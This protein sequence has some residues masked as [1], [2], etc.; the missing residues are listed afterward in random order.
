MPQEANANASPDSAP[1]TLGAVSPGSLDGLARDLAMPMPRGKALRTLAAGLVVASVPGMTA[2]RARA[3]DPPPPCSR[4]GTFCGNVNPLGQIGYNIGCCLGGPGETRTVCC[5]GIPG[6][7]GSLCCPTGY[8][9]GNK[10]KDSK[11]NCICR[12]KVVCGSTCCKP[13]EYC[14]FNLLGSNFCEKRCPNGDEKCIGN[15]CTRNEECGFFGCSCKSGFVSAGTGN[16]VPP[17]KDPGDPNPGYNPFRNMF[18]MMGQSSAASGGGRSRRAMF[19]RSDR[20]SSAAV[21]RALDA[22]AAVNGQGAAAMLAIRDGK[23][24]PAFRQKVKVARATPPKVS[25][26]AVLNAGS[27]AALNKLLVAEAE[28]YALIAAMTTAL[29]RFRAAQAKQKSAAGSQLRASATF[30]GQAVTALKKI[31]GLR[32]AAARALKGGKVPEAWAFDPAVNTFV[33]AVRSGG[34][35]ASLR[36]PMARLGVGS[37]DLKRLRAGVLD[38]AATSAVGPAL[39]APLQDPARA[40]DLRALISELSKYA[41]RAEKH[42]I[43]R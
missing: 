13:G 1:C 17:R 5:P 24:D 3:A 30:A 21:D 32:N 20:R 29:W 7:V 38:Q 12:S 6:V 9:C 14:Q 25:A 37:A 35:P 15:C 4:G 8:I 18:N 34:I 43:A 31:Q 26:D 42:P 39:I 11:E 19:A 27:A 33:A 36:T 10:S 40:K 28:A 16:C 2:R 22:L 41:V 23:R